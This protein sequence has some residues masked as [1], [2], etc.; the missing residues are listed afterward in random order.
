MRVAKELR[1]IDPKTQLTFFFN[2]SPPPP[3]GRDLRDRDMAQALKHTEKINNGWQERALCF[4]EEYCR[5]HYRFS[6]EM[7]R[8]EAKGI[9][10]E[11]PSLR[12]WG[13][14]LLTGSRRGW[15][16][17]VGFVTV[18]NPNAHRCLASQW[19]SLKCH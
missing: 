7:V 19:E 10:P 16:T 15:I 13:A 18:E 3:T 8:I 6:G 4:L 14:V 5:T 11:P 12:T 17:R 9:V 2:D 1:M